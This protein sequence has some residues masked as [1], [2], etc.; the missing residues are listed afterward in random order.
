MS[1]ILP[2]S[3]QTNYTLLCN[4]SQT[5]GYHAD[6]LTYLGPYPTIASLSLG[7]TRVFRLRGVQSLQDDA[8]TPPPRT[9]DIELPHNSLCIMGAGCQE[10]YK[11]TIPPARSIDVFKLRNGDVVET[12]IERINVGSSTLMSYLVPR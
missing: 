12:H 6:Q 2:K 4:V 3:T 10:K 9:Y 1:V 5:V 7:T 8:S 11:H